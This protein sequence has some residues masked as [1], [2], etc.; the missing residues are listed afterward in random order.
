MGLGVV[1]GLWPRR[2]SP[3]ELA[4]QAAVEREPVGALE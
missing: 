1:F 3:T 4:D 2:R